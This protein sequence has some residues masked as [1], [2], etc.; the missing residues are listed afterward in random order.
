MYGVS[1][2]VNKT[3]YS[4]EYG[5]IDPMDINDIIN[6]YDINTIT[7]KISSYDIS[8]V[9]YVY[10]SIIFNMITTDYLSTH[11]EFVKPLLNKILSIVPIYTTNVTED[12]I[13][14]VKYYNDIFHEL[15]NKLH[16]IDYVRSNI[17]LL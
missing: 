5:D 17:S 4:L 16:D 6:T 3:I 12:N 8:L 15:Y 9:K 1:D 11:L 10:T 13:R 2:S 7:N 14:K